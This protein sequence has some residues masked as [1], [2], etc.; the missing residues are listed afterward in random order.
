VSLPLSISVPPEIHH[1]KAFRLPLSKSP[2]GPVDGSKPVQLQLQ[3]SHRSSVLSPP[4]AEPPT[5]KQTGTFVLRSLTRPIVFVII[6]GMIIAYYGITGVTTALRRVDHLKEEIKGRERIRIY[7][8]DGS[9]FPFVKDFCSDETLAWEKC[10][11]DYSH[12][13]RVK[14][15]RRQIRELED[16]AAHVHKA[17][18]AC[19]ESDPMSDHWSVQTCIKN[20]LESE[21]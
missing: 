7:Q 5:V 19:R 12:R 2:S 6:L 1:L 9:Y 4:T 10:F 18:E 20:F 11:P 21:E 3:M 16:C 14:R 17:E 13:K 15:C 8:E